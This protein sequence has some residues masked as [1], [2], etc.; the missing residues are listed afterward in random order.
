MDEEMQQRLKELPP[1]FHASI[2]DEYAEKRKRFLER[3]KV[4]EYI[5]VCKLQ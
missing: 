3:E 2:Y 1:R 5:M 4:N